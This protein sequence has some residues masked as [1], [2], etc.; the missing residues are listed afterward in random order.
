M[1]RHKKAAKRGVSA[2]NSGP[3]SP[4]RAIERDGVRIARS[5]GMINGFMLVGLAH[6]TS[7]S[8]NVEKTGVS[9][10]SVLHGM[11][12]LLLERLKPAF[13]TGWA[14]AQNRKKTAGVFPASRYCISRTLAHR[15]KPMDVK[16][17]RYL[18]ALTAS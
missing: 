5:G 6:T 3:P 18:I 17:A 7:H 13:E 8:R 11:V 14:R 16:N 9:S 10:P 4:H 2:R 1:H 15:A 12:L